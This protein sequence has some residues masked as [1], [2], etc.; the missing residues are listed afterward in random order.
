MLNEISHLRRVTCVSVLATASS[1]APLRTE[2]QERTTVMG[3]SRVIHV[4]GSAAAV[5]F[6]KLDSVGCKELAESSV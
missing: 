2:A 5:P 1:I 6:A 3:A 4:A